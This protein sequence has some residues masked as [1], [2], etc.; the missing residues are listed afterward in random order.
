MMS[1]EK[2]Q[3][4][5]AERVLIRP[6]T[7]STFV[8]KKSSVGHIPHEP[9]KGA[10]G[11]SVCHSAVPTIASTA[12]HG[13]L[14]VT[15]KT[16]ESKQ[17]H[18]VSSRPGEIDEISPAVQSNVLVSKLVTEGHVS[19]VAVNSS[20]HMEEHKNSGARPLYTETAQ[21]SNSV[22]VGDLSTTVSFSDSVEDDSKT[23]L[24]P[25]TSLHHADSINTVAST[26]RSGN[27]EMLETEV[28]SLQEQLVIQS[29]VSLT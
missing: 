29:K 27:V 24:F 3:F 18:S 1:Q 25:R 28:M 16:N 20:S 12:A 22:H 9:S 21:V 2:Q 14:V 17:K 26:G 15:A 11:H 6:S 19:G 5:E 13:G 7:C 8:V 23:G 4:N 10:V